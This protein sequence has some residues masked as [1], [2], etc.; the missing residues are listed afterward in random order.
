[1][2]VENL[3]EATSRL[4][5]QSGDG[6]AR[7]VSDKIKDGNNYLRKEYPI[8][9]NTQ[10][11]VEDTW[12]TNSEI[13]QWRHYTDIGA[14]KYDK[15]LLQNLTTKKLGLEQEMQQLDNEVVGK[16]EDAI[17]LAYKVKKGSK[18]A[19]KIEE[20]LDYVFAQTGLHSLAD[21]L[22][23]R[24]I[25]GESIDK[26]KDEIATDGSKLRLIGEELGNY[27]IND[28]VGSQK[29]LNPTMVGYAIG[30]ADY[31]KA[32]QLAALEG[33]Q[34]I[35]GSVETIQ[36][37]YSK[38]NALFE[39]IMTQAV[40]TAAITHKTYQNNP[41]HSFIQKGNMVM[42]TMM[43]QKELRVISLKEYKR[44]KVDQKEGWE[45]LEAPT[46]ENVGI[47]M[48]ATTGQRHDGLAM[49]ASFV[50]T[51]LIV[52][53]KKLSKKQLDNAVVV[54]VDG[55]E[56][57][58]IGLTKESKA[59][60]K[61]KR[62]PAHTLV[63]SYAHNYYINK[64]QVMRKVM[65]QKI[66]A[67]RTAEDLEELIAIVKD[68]E[69][70]NPW[71]LNM[72]HL[73]V[74][75]VDGK[76]DAKIIKL[77][78]ELRKEYD[79]VGKNGVKTTTLEGLSGEITFVRNDLT[80]EIMG[81]KSMRFK[82]HEMNVWLDR[83]KKAV[84]FTKIQQILV[85]P[86]KI[87]FDATSGATLLST[88][89][90]PIEE[91]GRGYRDIPKELKDLAKLRNQKLGLE[92]RLEA[93]KSKE[94][95][96][97]LKNQIKSIDTQIKDSPVAVALFNGLIQSMSTDITLKNYDTVSG[98]D[99]DM[100][101]WVGK[102]ARQEGGDLNK[103]GKAIMMM[104]NKGPDFT[105]ALSWTGEKAPDEGAVQE[106][107]K[108]MADKLSKLKSDED[109]EGYLGE[110]IGSPSSE[111]VKL[112]SAM[113]QYSDVIP[114][115]IGI[116]Y[117]VR[118]NTERFVKKNNRQPNPDEASSIEKEAV[119]EML[120]AFGNYAKNMPIG[121][122]EA[123]S[124]FVLMYPSFW[125]R[126]QKVLWNLGYRHPVS[127]AMAIGTSEAIGTD[128]AHIF[129]VFI[130]NKYESGSILN[131]PTPLDIPIPGSNLF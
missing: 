20:Q 131:V 8:W 34:L 54:E 120:Q 99:A 84:V 4:M 25:A 104:A 74:K 36:E 64:T 111:I 115:I 83:V 46:E 109:I 92:I 53:P 56:M 75:T 12:R 48:R 61:Y 15:E 41:N 78:E 2:T 59:T 14:K 116:K 123:S 6:I 105:K 108:N 43:D 30:T 88:M 93:A 23:E 1:E 24:V 39:S 100:K 11:L 89:G 52:N 101:T 98:L 86:T 82:S 107:L 9:A 124:V 81:F 119:A 130:G 69:Q 80:Q 128:A 63:R 65:K 126:M 19:N 66:V 71:M 85:N 31:N 28:E 49:D 67:P 68:K 32:N 35:D 47:M 7:L 33:L 103:V 121:M 40:S 97:R 70:E 27:Y 96:S 3:N 26:L 5:R 72:N 125:A 16:M 102:I 50:S 90:V 118:V 113:T 29:A 79:L 76:A 55:R 112:G 127:L 87:A 58:H 117:L 22:L 60:L 114:R 129:G 37:L 17:H 94:D 10:D 122:S 42:D 91:L 13:S 44:G 18:E 110:F 73:E 38:H 21:G 51:G 106:L 77:K 57:V 95:I 45:I 62:S